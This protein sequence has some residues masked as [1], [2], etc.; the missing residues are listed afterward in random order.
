MLRLFATVSLAAL[1]APAVLAA[2]AIDVATQLP[3]SVVPSH[4][5]VTLTPDAENMTFAGQVA[6]DLEVK[7]PTDSITLQAADISFRSASLSGVGKAT[8]LTTD[9]KAQTATFG[10]GRT[11]APGKYTLSIDYDGK[12]ATQATGLFALDYDGAKGKQRALYTQF[13]NSDLRRMIPS[14]DEPSYKATFTMNAIVPKGQMAVSNMPVASRTDAGNGRE[15]VS[16]PVTPKMSTYLLFFGLGDFD[17][18]TTKAGPTEIGII[19]PAGKSAQGQYAL[20]SSVAVLNEYNDYFGVPYPL[21]KLDNVAAPGRS[22]FFGAMENWGAIFTFEGA[23]LLDPTIS[24]QADKQRSFEVAAHEI[25]HQWFGNL[26]TMAWWDD[27]WLNEGFASWMESRTTAKLNPEWHAELDTVLGRDSAM[28]R[29]ALATTHPVI[30]KIKT[31]EE[32]SLAFDAITYSKG[33]A[34]IR[35]L[36]NYVGSTAWRDG[37]RAY[38][39]QYAYQNTV[40]DDLWRAVDA[41]S[42]GKPITEIAHK[43]TLQP[44]VPMLTVGA[45]Q[46]VGGN[47]VLSLTQGEFSKDQPGKTPLIWPVPVVASGIGGQPVRTVVEGG[48]GSITVPGCAPVIIN[49]GQAGYYRTLYS[50]AAFSAVTKA[51]AQ[52]PAID[53]LGIITDSWALGMGGRQPAS[54][55]LGLVR[56]TPADADPQVWQRL[57]STL[58]SL[59]SYY[60]GS[61]GQPAFRRFAIA[62]LAPVFAR[63]GWTA[64]PGEPEPVAT[65]RNTLISTLGT[66][67]DPAVIAEARRLEAAGTVTP[68]I[69]KAVLDVV[70]TNAD[71]ATWNRLLGLAEAEKVPLV[72]QQYFDLLGRAKDPVLAQKALALALTPAP[73]ATNSA[74]IISEVSDVH[75]DLAFDFAL[76][77]RA[78]VA[79]LLDT[80]SVNRFFPGLAS[81]SSNL[82]TAAKVEADAKANIPVEARRDADTAAASIRYRAAILKDRLPEI[83]AWLVKNAG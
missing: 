71:A 65:L 79:K 80:T 24:T 63:V 7:A 40:T 46:C 32:A 35:M 66:L 67:G 72:R 8:S 62:E 50:P 2:P 55:I 81:G 60:A 22:Q 9:A 17:R 57:A 39:K 30:Q 53:Q 61:P 69:R 78:E 48:R 20:D 47:T 51:F 58:A 18:I 15:K 68:A 59:D 54:D 33:Q 21:P 82:A 44:G 31:V 12:I 26:V 42:P 77:H 11:L 45:P 52:V 28:S 56:A 19:T 25:A 73:G 64:K 5:D 41:A 83:D 34:V 74:G 49:S 3:R 10:F 16:F 43:F 27:L 36:E 37:V 38:M 76:A 75:P 29:D 6:I 23:I 1:V 70:A 14:W 13:E 4:Y